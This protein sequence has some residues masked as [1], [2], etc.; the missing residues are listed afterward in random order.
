MTKALQR[1]Q[2]GM[3]QIQ[4]VLPMERVKVV[5]RRVRLGAV[6]ASADGASHAISSPCPPRAPTVAMRERQKVL[7]RLS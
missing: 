5:Y 7:Q 6:S 1:V 4:H 2:E 3:L